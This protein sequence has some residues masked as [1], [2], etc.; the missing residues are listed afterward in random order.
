MN[1]Y[2]VGVDYGSLSARALLLNLDTG[3]EAAV[4]EFAYPHAV[5]DTACL[6][7]TSRC[8]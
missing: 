4:S 7:Y 2:A 1:R 8:V 3:E 6:L 5:M